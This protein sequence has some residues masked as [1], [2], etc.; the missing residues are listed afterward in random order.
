MVPTWPQLGSQNIAKMAKKSIPNSIIF[1]GC[2]VGRQ[3]PPKI[4]QKSHRK[5][6]AQ[7]EGILGASWAVFGLSRGPRRTPTQP[8][9]T[10]RDPARPSAP[11]ILSRGAAR[12]AA[13]RAKIP[14]K[15]ETVLD[16]LTRLGPEAG[17]FFDVEGF[18]PLYI[19]SS[20][21][22]VTL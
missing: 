14:I 17:E 9:A 22:L 12:A 6:E 20:R 16:V 10:Q 2:Q 7:K 5:N 1:L 3:N 11:K 8:N 21:H 13:L 15:K 18:C 4:D 19:G